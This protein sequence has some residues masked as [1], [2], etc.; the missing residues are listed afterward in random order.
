MPFIEIS[1]T[2]EIFPFDFLFSLSKQ[3]EAVLCNKTYLIFALWIIEGWYYY[4]PKIFSD[5]L[6][7]SNF[8]RSI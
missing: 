3:Y 5:V 2:S 6:N 4:V 7:I 8:E 1:G